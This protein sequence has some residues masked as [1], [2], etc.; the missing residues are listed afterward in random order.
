MVIAAACH[1]QID[2][3][4]IEPSV[5]SLAARGDGASLWLQFRAANNMTEMQQ[6]L[7]DAAAAGFPQAQFELATAML[8]GQKGAS[9]GA[10]NSPSAME[11]LRLAAEQ[12]PGAEAQLAVCEYSGCEGTTPDID[13]AVSHARDAAKNGAIDAILTIGPHLAAGQIKPDEI[14]AWNIL[15][16]AIQQRG[17]SVSILNVD[18]MQK[19]VATLASRAQASNARALADQYWRDYGTTILGNLACS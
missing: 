19:T 10:P 18:W 14:N 2:T 4:Q 3:D 9:D 11:L 12:L 6:R 7:R 15:H 1:R 16:A 5:A 8:A 17:C 13:A